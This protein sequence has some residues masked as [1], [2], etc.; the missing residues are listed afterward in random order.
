[1]PAQALFVDDSA[2]VVAAARAAGVRYI[3]QVL[4]PDSTQ[5]PHGLVEGFEGVLRLGDLLD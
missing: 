1:V 2:A 4:Q 3:Y 5:P